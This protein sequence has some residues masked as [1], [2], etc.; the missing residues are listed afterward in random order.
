MQFRSDIKTV[1]GSCAT[2]CAAITSVPH[3][4]AGTGVSPVFVRLHSEIS[5]PLKFHNFL[6]LSDPKA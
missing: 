6:L 5:A 3:A 2:I 1:G 4:T